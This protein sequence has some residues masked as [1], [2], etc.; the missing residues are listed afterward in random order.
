MSWGVRSNPA[1][2]RPATDPSHPTY[3]ETCR[4]VRPHPGLLCPG[5]CALTLR[6]RAPL[7]TQVIQ[8]ILKPVG[9]CDL[10]QAYYV[11]GSAL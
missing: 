9:R 8:P 3:S 4:S 5:E 6:Y 7:Q 10:T 11:L 1:L 2:S